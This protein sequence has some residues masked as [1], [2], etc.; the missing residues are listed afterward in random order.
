M[1]LSLILVSSAHLAH[2]YVKGVAIPADFEEVGRARAL[3]QVDGRNTTARSWTLLETTDG[4]AR[5]NPMPV[6]GW[7]IDPTYISDWSGHP[8]LWAMGGA[9]RLDGE[10]WVNVDLPAAQPQVGQG[11]GTGFA[12]GGSDGLWWA[13]DLDSSWENVVPGVPFIAVAVSVDGSRLAGIDHSGQVYLGDGEAVE[14]LPLLQGGIPK[15]LAVGDVL[16]AATAD[17]ISVWRD[18][19]WYPCAEL[20]ASTLTNGEVPVRLA[21]HGAALVVGTGQDLAFSEDLCQSFERRVPFPDAATYGEDAGTAPSVGAAVTAI[22]LGD[23][24][25]L[26][27]GY[28]GIAVQRSRQEAYQRPR[29]W[30]GG[31]V[32]D[33]AWDA[34]KNLLLATSYGSGLQ[35]YGSG[36][37]WSSGQASMHR[38]DA[39]GRMVTWLGPDRMLYA[40][41]LGRPLISEDG[42]AIWSETDMLGEKVQG[43]WR[44]GDQS[45]AFVAHAGLFRS[46]DGL[47]WTLVEGAPDPVVAVVRGELLEEEG[48][49]LTS[50]AQV[51]DSYFLSDGA[52]LREMIGPKGPIFSMVSWPPGE[53]QRLIVG[54]R[55]GIAS[56]E[57]GGESYT[58]VLELPGGALSLVGA[59]DGTLL[60]VDAADGLWRSKDG[61]ES[62][63]LLPTLLPPIQEIEVASDFASRK[64]VVAA[65]LLGLYWSEDQGD[66][67]QEAGHADVLQTEDEE[68]EPFSPTVPPQMVGNVLILGPGEGVA[69]WTRGSSVTV[70]GSGD[71]R[72][73]VEL[74]GE[75]LGE[76]AVG[77]V[78][79]LPGAGWRRLRI[80]VVEGEV[81]LTYLSMPF[82]GTPMPLSGALPEPIPGE[83]VP[84]CGCGHGGVAG[85]LL[86]FLAWGRRRR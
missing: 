48:F 42:G 67:W 7:K 53:G 4:G 2:D 74:D 49:F 29:M 13:S 9:L 39:Y 82:E 24:T 14:P 59:D 73:R 16:Y 22:W 36:G 81:G 77:E 21:V 1:L 57:D 50:S 19:Q 32:R 64:L 18:G 69:P 70:E 40:G 6:P 79:A 68:L 71:G 54:D 23:H 58:R 38:Q 45:W 83:E 5:W 31:F 34:S 41:D 3:V 56:S 78:L 63:D 65:T 60:A 8:M 43:M 75:G 35:L 62:W 27:G 52:E 47:D 46:L 33:L 17:A 10:Q 12:I 11:G 84:A 30:D 72:M 25:T 37:M 85:L 15:A 28:R 76:V 80:E 61:G 66:S 26:V 51:G 55:D 20:P 86:P 44:A